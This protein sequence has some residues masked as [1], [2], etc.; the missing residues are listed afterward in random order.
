MFEDLL[1]AVQLQISE[2]LVSPL[3]GA[4]AVSW[5]LWN[6][7]FLV[8]LLSK[9]PVARSFKM[10]D[11]L[12]YP[13][14]WSFGLLGVALPLV[15]SLAYIFLYPYPARFVF[16]F[17][18]QRQRELLDIKRKMEDETPLTVEESRKLR[19]EAIRLE[20]SFYDQLERR[21]RE[22]ERLKDELAAAQ[23]DAK[24]Q[25]S[26]A[27]VR[28]AERA[29]IALSDSQTQLLK[30][31]GES[32]GMQRG[33]ISS[34]GRNRIEVDF[35]LGELKNGGLI[36]SFSARMDG[37]PFTGLRLTHEGRRAVLKAEQS[38]Q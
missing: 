20:Q 10:I 28:E 14:W 18:R 16:S 17:T 25:V 35:D 32:P 9:E 24:T 33:D 5:S 38:H 19:R 27:P 4:F 34:R 7:K 21:D 8:I 6:Y 37:R 36:E 22:I 26:D 29:P 3:M 13:H 1:K 11:A 12:A 30:M 15:T 2:R 23:V 31:I